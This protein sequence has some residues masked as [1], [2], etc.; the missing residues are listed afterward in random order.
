MVAVGSGAEPEK[1]AGFDPESLRRAAGAA[2]RAL[3][4]AKKAAFAL[5]LAEAAD[6][7]VVAE[8]LLLGAYSFDAYKESAKEARRAKGNG[9]APLAEAV[10][11]GGKPRTRCTRRRSSAPWPSPRS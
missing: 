11:L 6:A 4:G 1:D 9:K 5:P 7:G 10:L 8:G 3:A 2:A